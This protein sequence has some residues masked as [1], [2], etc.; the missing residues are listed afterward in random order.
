MIVGRFG[1]TS[2][3]PYINGYVV[4]PSLG[5]RSNVSFIVDTGADRCVLMP[6]DG[7]LFGIDYSRLTN[8]SL[9]LGIGGLSKDYVEPAVIAFVE[10]NKTLHAFSIDLIL[11]SPSPDIMT[12]PSL[13]GRNILDRWR[14]TYWPAGATLVAD[15]ISSDLAIPPMAT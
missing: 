6:M 1:D 7:A 9:S 11:S 10:D 12:V 8:T 3:R 5:A 4:I 13:L 15:V 14:I 2:R